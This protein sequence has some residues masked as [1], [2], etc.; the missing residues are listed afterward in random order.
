MLKPYVERQS[1]LANTVLMDNDIDSNTGEA[2]LLSELTEANVSDMGPSA[3]DI[4]PGFVLDHLE[5]EQKS[6]VKTLL[7]KYADIFN[8]MPGR[9]TL[10]SHSI[11]LL[12][13]AKPFKLPPYRVHPEKT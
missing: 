6:Q 3:S 13:G 10:G 9:T 5:P 2:V 1:M 4:D 11:R 7:L 12:E 8:D